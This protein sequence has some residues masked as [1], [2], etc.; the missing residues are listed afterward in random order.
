MIPNA[1]TSAQQ[2]LMRRRKGVFALGLT[3]LYTL[4]TTQPTHA[5]EVRYIFFDAPLSTAAI[6]PR[7]INREGVVTGFYIDN[8]NFVEHGFLRTADGTVI[9]VD[10]AGP[11]FTYG[12]GIDRAGAIAGSYDDANYGQHGFVRSPDGT[13]TSFDPPGATNPG[14][15]P[16]TGVAAMNAEGTITGS[17]NHNDKFLGGFLRYHDST[18]TEFRVAGEF[19]TFPMGINA[20]DEVTG[21]YSDPPHGFLRGR[22]GFLITFDVPGATSTTPVGIS[23]KG[24]ISGTY[25]DAN[26]V[27]HGFVRSRD[28][29]F[30]MLD[31]PGAASTA[32]T[33]INS[34]GE[35]TGYWTDANGGSHGFVRTPEGILTT[36]DAPNA[37]GGTSAYAI[38][39]AGTI[40]GVAGSHVF[41][42]MEDKDGEESSKPLS[43]AAGLFAVPIPG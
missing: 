32:P 31:V 25:N 42:R 24:A 27:T 12:V 21:N 10:P 16:G 15:G 23:R 13:N 29:T 40:T 7:A 28:G 39:S 22:N 18:F 1:L 38:N 43:L 36:F 30:T 37:I 11:T 6:Q 8:T 33:A 35:I 14:F 26:N 20:A 2:L 19:I 4:V 3:L 41:I 17:Y 5:Q 34:K 9:T